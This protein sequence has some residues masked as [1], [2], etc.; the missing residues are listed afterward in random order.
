M[1]KEKKGIFDFMLITQRDMHSEP[2]TQVDFKMSIVFLVA[3]VLFGILF[4]LFAF[5]KC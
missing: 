2:L 3:L 4:W 1:E 5:E